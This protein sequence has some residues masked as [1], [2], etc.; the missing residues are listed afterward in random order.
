M[1]TVPFIYSFGRQPIT[2]VPAWT[3]GRMSD[4][5][6]LVLE[7]RSVLVWRFSS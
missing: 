7:S 3:F 2:A 1:T 4:T 6:G 5:N